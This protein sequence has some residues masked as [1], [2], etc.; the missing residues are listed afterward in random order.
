MECR[1]PYDPPPRTRDAFV[2]FDGHGRIDGHQVFV[3]SKDGYR[4]PLVDY[5]VQA[6]QEKQ[7]DAF[8]EEATTQVAA[9]HQADPKAIVVWACSD[10]DVV[11][12]IREYFEKMGVEVVVLYVAP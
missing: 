9:A 8:L 3:D 2:D 7:L 1:Q 5:P 11:P 12:V 10:P 6:I 4:F